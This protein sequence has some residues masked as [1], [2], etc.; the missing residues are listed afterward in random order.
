MRFHLLLVVF[1]VLFVSN[2]L[3]TK[4]PKKKTNRK[5]TVKNDGSSINVVDRVNVAR[6]EVYYGGDLIV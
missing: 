2:S 4:A 3:A 1:F 6:G 5:I